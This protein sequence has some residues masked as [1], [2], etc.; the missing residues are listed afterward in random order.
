[1]LHHITYQIFTVS[2]SNLL[3]HSATRIE[4]VESVCLCLIVKTMSASLLEHYDI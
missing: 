1:M 2:L 3:S 4:V